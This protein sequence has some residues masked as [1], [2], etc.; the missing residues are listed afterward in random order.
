[1]TIVILM[2]AF[3]AVVAVVLGGVAWW[4]RSHGESALFI[5]SAIAAAVV[6][7]VGIGMV[8]VAF[9]V[10]HSNTDTTEKSDNS[11]SSDKPS[12]HSDSSSGSESDS[13]NSAD[14]TA[15]TAALK[16]TYGLNVVNPEVFNNSE[17]DGDLINAT[18]P[19]V[20]AKL[21]GATLVCTVATGSTPAQVTAVCGGGAPA[22]IA[23]PAPPPP[24][25]PTPH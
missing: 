24:P 16:A 18:F 5:G 3:V 22:Q 23:T 9:V 7:V 13:S 20:I 17:N 1:M 25:A 4:S 6:V 8:P 19:N 10:S 15:I 2:C 11:D 21:K 12:D 14:P